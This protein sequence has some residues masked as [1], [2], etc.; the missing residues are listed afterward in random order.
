MADGKMNRRGMER[1]P[2]VNKDAQEAEKYPHSGTYNAA[3]Q[4]I[5]GVSQLVVARAPD[6]VYGKL[7]RDE[8]DKYRNRES[9]RPAVG[10][11]HV[12]S[13]CQIS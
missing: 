6:A 12:E 3:T 2:F 8:R 9:H 4:A 10:G 11:V 5:D 7:Q 13:P 1:Y